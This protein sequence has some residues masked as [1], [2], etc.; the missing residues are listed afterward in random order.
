[1]TLTEIR[2]ALKAAG[3]KT[4]VSLDRVHI[5]YEFG[6][7][8]GIDVTLTDGRVDYLPVESSS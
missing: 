7:V 3:Y 1:M 6:K 2:N 8:A 4:N 5:K